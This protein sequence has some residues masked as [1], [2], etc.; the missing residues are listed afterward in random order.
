M[1]LLSATFAELPALLQNRGFTRLWI[2]QGLG[3]V[4]TNILHFALVLRTFSVTGSSFF[5]GVLIAVIS[6]PPI[7]FST[8]GGVIADRYD[9]WRSAISPLLAHARGNFLRGVRAVSL[10]ALRCV[11]LPHLSPLPSVSLQHWSALFGACVAG[12][13]NMLVVISTRTFIQRETHDEN[14]GKVFGSLL[15]VMNA[16]GLP[17]ILLLSHLGSLIPLSALFTWLS[18]FT[19]VMGAAGFWPCA[20]RCA[21]PCRPRPLPSH[22]LTRVRIIRYSNKAQKY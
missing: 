3:Q 9:R 1:S 4:A 2:S 18:S 7:L 22:S 19:M 8:V 20:C 10:R 14:R 6:L 13:G 16:I 21:N 5:V 17:I 15:T 12:V 11:A